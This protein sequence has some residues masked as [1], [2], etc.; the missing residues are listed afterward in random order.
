MS[1]NMDKYID[2][3]LLQKE[4]EK[5]IKNDSSCPFIQ[6]DFGIE[7]R[8]EG[9]IQGY[10]ETLA[11][12]DSLQQEQQK[13]NLENEIKDYTETLY[14]ETFGNGQGTLD[15]FDWEDIVQVIDNTAR[16]FYNLNKNDA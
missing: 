3:E 13:S 8:K 14:H 1:L 9:E 2:A 16:Y 12:V 10:K 4:I 11:I 15:E 5:R 7:C 6:A